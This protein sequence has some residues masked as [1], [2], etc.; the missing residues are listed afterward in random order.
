MTEIRFDVVVDVYK[1]AFA[2]DI[3]LDEHRQHIYGKTYQGCGDKVEDLAANES[4]AEK[5]H[6]HDD[7]HD[8]QQPVARGIHLQGVFSLLAQML[9]CAGD[10]LA[11]CSAQYAS[12]LSLLCL[13]SMA[14]M[15][16]VCKST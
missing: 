1:A 13:A 8:G 7:G 16:D 9:R 11:L 12:K 4:R 15:I 10:E 5:C 3:G 14:L 6:H 2:G